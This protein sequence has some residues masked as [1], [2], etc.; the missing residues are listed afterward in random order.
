MMNQLINRST[1]V[2]LMAAEETS[3]IA[4][5]Q[6]KMILAR[7]LLQE[8]LRHLPLSILSAA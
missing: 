1:S 2:G 5:I 6:A 8:A 4:S 3:E 7:L